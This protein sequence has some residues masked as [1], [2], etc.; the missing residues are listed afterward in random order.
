[1][2]QTASFDRL[3]DIALTFGPPIGVLLAVLMLQVLFV[4]SVTAPPIWAGMEPPGCYLP[5]PD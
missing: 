2:P 1:M 5:K 3:A 4:L